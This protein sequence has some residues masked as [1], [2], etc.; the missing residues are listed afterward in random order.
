MKNYRF[1]ISPRRTD[2]PRSAGYLADA[3]ALG[4]TS[5]SGLRCHDLYFIEGQLSEA[6]LQRLAVELLSDPV[7][8][9]YAYTC[10]TDQA[11]PSSASG[12][13]EVALRPGVTDPVAEQIV[14]GARELGIAGVERASTGLRFEIVVEGKNKEI[15]HREHGE[16]REEE[17]QEIYRG[18]RRERGDEEEKQEINHGDTE[19]QRYFENN[20]SVLN[21]LAKRLLANAVIQ[22]YAIGEIEPVFPHPAEASGNVESLPVCDL[23]EAGLLALSRERRAALDLAEMQAIQGYFRREEREPSDVEIETIAQTWSE[24]CGHKTFK[25]RI[26]LTGPSSPSPNDPFPLKGE[27]QVKG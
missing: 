10:L 12:V 21:L 3:H 9:D 24:H 20:S 7:T 5:V 26:T 13:V 8:Q 15:H 25:A 14:R 23:D 1:V 19:T 22:R 2:D 11:A 17:N 16:H 6:D 18:E 4:L 27:G